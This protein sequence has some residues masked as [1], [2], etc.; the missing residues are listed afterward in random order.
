MQ[1]KGKQWN[2]S[3]FPT[4]IFAVKRS[5]WT[6]N[7]KSGKVENGLNG[8]LWTLFNRLIS[9]VIEYNL[10]THSDIRNC[11][12][13][14]SKTIFVRI[15]FVCGY[16]HDDGQSNFLI[17][18]EKC[19]RAMHPFQKCVFF[20][21]DYPNTPIFHKLTIKNGNWKVFSRF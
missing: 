19:C 15:I 8:K 11:I 4:P 20:F 10:E 6:W 16:L 3:Y 13:F 1:F 21:V 9:N 7:I 14:F 18:E 17:F 12:E 5:H 2:R